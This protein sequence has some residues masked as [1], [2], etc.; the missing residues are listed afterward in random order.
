MFLQ[1]HS[2]YLGIIPVITLISTPLGHTGKLLNDQH[3][4]ELLR[5]LNSQIFLNGKTCDKVTNNIPVPD[6]HR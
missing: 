1:V 5:S 4:N 6:L 3:L 2:D